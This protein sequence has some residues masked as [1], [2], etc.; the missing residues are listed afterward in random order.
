MASNK[1]LELQ[2]MSTE[3]LNSQLAEAEVSM[4]KMKFDHTVNGIANPLELRSS[5]RDIARIKTELRR[6]E[7][8][9]T[10]PEEL[11]KRDRIIFRRRKAKK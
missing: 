6:R 9:E 7:L 3:D 10:S 11:V 5:R 4:Q 1:F 2:A 8:A